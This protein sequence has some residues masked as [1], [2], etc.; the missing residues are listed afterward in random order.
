MTE[1]KRPT[2]EGADLPGLAPS[3]WRSPP[4]VVNR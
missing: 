2:H 1:K 4:T 3:G